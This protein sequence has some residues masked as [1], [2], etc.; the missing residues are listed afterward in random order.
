MRRLIFTI[1]IAICAF[2]LSAMDRFV[3]LTS[4]NPAPPYTNWDTAAH[5]IQDAID[6]ADPGDTVNVTN[7]VY[8]IGGRSVTNTSDSTTNRIAIT[9]PLTIQSVNGPGVTTIQGNP[10]P[11]VTNLNT[12]VRCVYMTSNSVLSGFTIAYGTA[13][14]GGGVFCQNPTNSILSNCV[15]IANY[16]QLWGGGVIFGTLNDC[17]VASNSASEGGGAFWTSMRHCTIT[18]NSTGPGT[19]GAAEGDY[20]TA[21]YYGLPPGTLDNCTIVGNIGGGAYRA[22]LNNCILTGNDIACGDS[23]LLNCTVVSNSV[24]AAASF[25][26]NSIVYYNINADHYTLNGSG[27]FMYCCTTSDQALDSIYNHGNITNEPVFV[28]AAAGNFRLAP[29]SPCI[30]S[31][32]PADFG[33]TNDFDGNPRVVGGTVDI[34]AFEYQSPTS[35][36]S[37]AWLQQY[38]FSLDGSADYLDPD[39]DGLNNFQ[40][41]RAGTVPLDSTSVLLMSVPVISP[42]G[43]TLTWQSQTNISYYVQRTPA[44]SAPFST[45]QSNIAGQPGTTSFTDTNSIG[46]SSLFYRVGVQ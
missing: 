41:W 46:N 32:N 25:C 3:S 20:Y 40:E 19:S 9:K 44:L 35:K 13:Q 11:G 17:L 45:I 14:I 6:A 34:G 22:V 12:G 23:R 24:G 4:P 15:I 8:F 27:F 30:N 43:T 26:T 33:L 18:G 21:Q 1:F 10:D 16:A 7:G 38:G 42:A 5:V 37:Y 29:T 2:R 31:G 28:D 39:G 36:V